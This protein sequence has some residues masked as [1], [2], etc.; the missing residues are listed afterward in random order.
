MKNTTIGSLIT[1]NKITVLLVFAV[2]LAGSIISAGNISFKTQI[3]D[4]MHKDN[5]RVQAF[6]EIL[7]TFETTSSVIVTVEGENM[8]EMIDTAEYLSHSLQND[9]ELKE[10]L[11]AVN[12]KVDENLIKEWGLQFAEN[13]KIKMVSYLASSPNL[14]SVMEI[15]SAILDEK[16][17]DMKEIYF[18]NNSRKGLKSEQELK[19]ALDSL[20]SL[21]NLNVLMSGDGSIEENTAK[22]ISSLLGSDNYFFSSDYSML[23][24][25][26]TPSISIEDRK[27]LTTFI[28]LLNGHI[29]TAETKFDNIK[30]N[31]AGDLPQEADEEAAL[32]FDLVYPALLSLLLIIILFF[33]FLHGIRSVLFAGLAL[34]CGILLDIGIIGLTIKELNMMTSSFGALLIGL[35]IDFGIHVINAYNDHIKNGFSK[36]EAVCEMYRKI[37]KPVLIGG[38][39]TAIAF[40]ALGLS[41]SKGISQFGI[42]A[43]T[44][45]ITILISMLIFLPALLSSFG[46]KVIKERKLKSSN[47]IKKIAFPG[48]KQRIIIIS[49]ALLFTILAGINGSRLEF[50]PD[51]RKIGPQ[52]TP[53]K[54]TEAILAEKLDISPFPAFYV[55]DNL[56]EAEEITLLLRKENLV[57]SVESISDILSASGIPEER[58]LTIRQIN[59]KLQNNS[60]SPFPEALASQLTASYNKVITMGT[61]YFKKLEEFAAM[62]SD[63][64]KAVSMLFTS[65]STPE[66]LFRQ[67]EKNIETLSGKNSRTVETANT[68]SRML[69]NELKE[70]TSNNSALSPISLPEALKEQYTSK[71]G[72]K[73]LLTIFPTAETNS[74]EGTK[75]FDEAMKA[76]NPK[77]CSTIALGLELS[78]EITREAKKSSL[79]ILCI[80]A[81]LL[82]ITFRNVWYSIAALLNLGI[83]AVWMIGLFTFYGEL[84]IINTLAIPLIIGIG[85]DY[86]IHMIHSL[87]TGDLSQIQQTIKAIILSALTTMIGFGSLA[88]IGSFKGIASLGMILFLGALSCLIS[89]LLVI[90]AMVKKK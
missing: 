1:K 46:R 27:A 14:I 85:I 50:N 64:K 41:G 57:S 53:A 10:I 48:K 66:D 32:G 84:N 2:L 88:L 15:Y 70:M 55:A 16:T 40:F 30:I 62:D 38:M 8:Q 65:I 26:I 81:V 71:D 52:N 37:G 5:P 80:T 11:R 54:K 3:K 4:M 61:E 51:F 63:S 74:K 33:I 44:G 68:F 77:I 45:I 6:Q 83:S 69:V 73:F 17:K 79:I 49:A 20:T 36:N 86:S 67:M 28:D 39:T 47:F 18:S 9:Q 89:S 7:E 72:S 58:M 90:P 13:E 43:G 24:F 56:K 31:T 21:Y 42:V 29:E 22:V 87:K 82:L 23:L 59:L 78:N 12:L 25:T 76:V 35:G 34:I 19:F 60:A 75:A